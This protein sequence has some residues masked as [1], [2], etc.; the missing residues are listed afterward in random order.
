M[1]HQEK[2]R[3]NWW[4]VA[5]ITATIYQI[6]WDT[7]MDWELFVFPPIQPSS[8]SYFRSCITFLS[9]PIQYIQSIQ[10]RTNRLYKTTSIYHYIFCINTIFR[11]TWMLCFIPAYHLSLRSGIIRPTF[12]R[13]DVRSYISPTLSALEVVRRMLWCILKLEIET[14]KMTN[15]GGRAGNGAA[16]FY[17]PLPSFEKKEEG[18]EMETLDGDTHDNDEDLHT[19]KDTMQSSLEVLDLHPPSLSLSAEDHNNDATD[20]DKGLFQRLQQSDDL[21][22]DSNNHSHDTQRTISLTPSSSP[23]ILS[24]IKTSICLFFSLPIVKR[25]LFIAELSLWA[26]AYVALGYWSLTLESHKTKSI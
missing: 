20:E 15:V 5:F 14:M 10:L 22:D 21:F 16:L 7:V 6:V 23:S 26:I 3:S 2:S 9:S 4:I 11:F 1:S 18:I 8:P 24:H 13:D 25:K 17:D 12:S 19:N